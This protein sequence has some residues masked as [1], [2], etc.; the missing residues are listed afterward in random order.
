MVP[1]LPWILSFTLINIGVV[2][3]LAAC[4]SVQSS[5]TPTSISRVV[6]VA[7]PSPPPLPLILSPAISDPETTQKVQDY[8][9]RL[10]LPGIPS[11]P[12]GIWIQT[13]QTLLANEQG[14]T[15]LGAA[16]LTK[17]ATS[18]V[19][20]QTLGVDYQ[21]ITEISITGEVKNGILNGDLWLQGGGDPFLV[22]EEAIALGNL[23]NQIGIKKVNGNLIISDKFYMNFE[24]D[25]IKSGELWREAIN[26]NTWSGEAE[27]AYTNLSSKAPPT[28]APPS[29]L[30]SVTVLTPSPTTSPNTLPSL[31]PA[32]TAKPQ[33]VITGNVKTGATIPAN[34]QLILRHY[35]PPLTEL[36]KKM[37]QYSNNPMAEMIADSVGGGKVVAKKAAVAI[38]VPEVEIQLENGSGLSPKNLISPRAVVGLFLALDKLMAA[39]N[40]SIADTLTI[41]GQD[42]GVLESRPLPPNT[43]AKSG[44]L[45]TVS[46]LGGVLPTE[47]HGLVWFAVLNNGDIDLDKA[48][49]EQETFLATLLKDW[50]PAKIIP[51]QLTASAT[52]KNKTSRSE[53]LKYLNSTPLQ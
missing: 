22:W 30:N 16:S 36:V 15:P 39:N 28:P 11:Q 23:L 50:Q 32:P 43:I 19:A 37:N 41:I 10:K 17:V 49:R 25:P 14:T 8:L 1:K 34:A 20:L 45:N 51:A 29:T 13:G 38:E 18:L 3:F 35:S 31:N 24:T 53:V 4:N 21:Y 44:T 6:P 42:S 9:K 52:R 40:L 47:K 5:V 33:V 48:R 2:S 7:I 26:A 27:A 46:A 12:N